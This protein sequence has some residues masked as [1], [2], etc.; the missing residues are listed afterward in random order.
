MRLFA[1]THRVAAVLVLIAA[2]VWILTGE[3]SSVGSKE[4]G[5]AEANAAPKVEEDVTSPEVGPVLRTVAAIEPV[6]AEHSRI[7]NLPGTT[8]PDK[9]AVLAAR[10]NGVIDQLELVKGQAIETDQV[11]MTLEGPEA[12]AS[13]RIAEIAL[14]QRERELEIAERLYANG[15]T[16]ELQLINA[17]AARD[18]AESE[19]SLAR[20]AVDRLELKAP[21]SGLVD[22]VDVERGEWVLIGAP[23]ATIL[24]LDP[25]VALAEVS[26]LDI[27]HVVTGAKATVR[28]IDGTTMDGSVRFVAREASSETRTFPV[29]IALPNPDLAIPVGM[30]IEVELFADAVRAV[31]IPRSIIT[32]SDEGELGV[33][34]AGADNIARFAPVQVIDDTEGG[35]IV[36]GVPEDVRIIVA[37]QDLVRNG[38]EVILAD[39][40]EATE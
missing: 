10:S 36:T 15:N 40:P 18:A 9:R 32:L 26:E 34:V 25:V 20:A 12:L 7:I 17:R 4:G 2:G 3:F 27:G 8:Q 16:P 30:T 24:S 19:L 28:M 35:L 14:D 37:G 5:Y 13:A 1:R 39:V 6:F 11:V 23:V 33:R 31:T 38:D 21:F 22:T 29:E